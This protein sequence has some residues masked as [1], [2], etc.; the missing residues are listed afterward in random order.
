MDA[1]GRKDVAAAH[2]NARSATD[3]LHD[4]YFSARTG[5]MSPEQQRSRLEQARRQL[6]SALHHTKVALDRMY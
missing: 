6:A 4:V 5:A 1:E 2:T 3:A